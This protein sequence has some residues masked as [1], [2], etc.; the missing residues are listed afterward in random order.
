MKVA[1]VSGLINEL[2]Y[3][4]IPKGLE[5]VFNKNKVYKFFKV[6]YELKQVL[7]L[8]YKDYLSSYLRN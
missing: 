5:N 1:F 3:I 8:W 2:V 4:Q 7:R 6:L